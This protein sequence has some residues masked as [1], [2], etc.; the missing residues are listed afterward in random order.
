M[1]NSLDFKEILRSEIKKKTILINP[2]ALTEAYI[3]DH[4]LFREEEME[5]ITRYLGRFLSGV[6]PGNLLI[7]GPPGTGKTHAMKIISHNYREF[8]EE[9][10]INSRIVY[11]N[12]KDKTYYQTLVSLLHG[13]GIEFPERGFGT[14]E[15]VQTL[16]GFMKKDT[17]RHVFV[18]DEIDKL[19]K[20]YRDR[21]DPVNALVYRMSRLDELL[22]RGGPMV[23]MISNM[24]TIVERIEHATMAKFIPRV[25][26]FRDYNVDEL[27]HILL[28]RAQIALVEGSYGEKTL[29]YLAELIKRNERDL[30]WG[31][32]V[33]IEAALISQDTLGLEA[34]DRAVSLV[35]ADM[36]SQ[37]LRSLGNHHLV[38]LW[39]VAFLENNGMLPVTGEVYQLYKIACE[40]FGWQP[41]S[42]RHVMH[43]ITPK[44]EGIGLITSREKGQGRG[45]GKTLVFHIEE[46]T[47]QILTTVEKILSERLHRK[48]DPLEVPELLQVTLHKRR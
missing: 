27:Y 40:E 38:V 41:R 30:R 2:T 39:S 18:F 10:G 21:E 31:F 43:Y 36:L 42:M 5:E 15:A 35:D 34:V 44:V 25:I 20:T 4:L 28:S 24:S 9:L 3:P 46:R 6:Q 1:K 8:V 45:R 12:C 17:G 7:H 29:R 47:E 19:K 22:P 11:V 26:Y 23:V 37:V 48:F 16:V 14:A 13:L 33:L 32:R